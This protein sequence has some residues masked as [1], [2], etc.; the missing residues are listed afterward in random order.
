MEYKQ[1]INIKIPDMQY[2]LHLNILKIELKVPSENLNNRYQ[3][4]LKLLLLLIMLMVLKMFSY[5]INEF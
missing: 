3:R 4:E 1:I 2:N 5:K